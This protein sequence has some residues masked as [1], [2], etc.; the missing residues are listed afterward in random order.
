M[1]A[2]ASLLLSALIFSGTFALA[3]DGGEYGIHLFFDEREFVDVMTVS[4]NP[5]GILEGRMFVPQ[6]FEGPLLDLKIDDL[7]I[8]FDLLVPKNASRPTDL[9]FH[10]VGQ[11][12]DQKKEQITG[13][14]T[15]RGSPEFTASFVAFKRKP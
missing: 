12:F 9:I 14:V 1:K 8:E 3:R 11:F 5:E 6:D 2:L 4:K 7:K 10:Y 15:I 13:F